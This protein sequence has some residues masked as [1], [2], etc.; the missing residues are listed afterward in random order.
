MAL[1]RTKTCHK[2]RTLAFCY[3]GS[4]EAGKRAIGPKFKPAAEEMR[5]IKQ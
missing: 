2:A 5:G 3:M 1:K 4:G